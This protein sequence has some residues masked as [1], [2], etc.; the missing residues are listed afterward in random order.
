MTIQYINMQNKVEFITLILSATFWKAWK[1]ND[2]DNTITSFSSLSVNQQHE[3]RRKE[4]EGRKSLLVSFLYLL[5]NMMCSKICF[6]FCVPS[7]YLKQCTCF[8]FITAYK[9]SIHSFPRRYNFWR[10]CWNFLLWCMVIVHLR[11]CSK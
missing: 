10:L 9:L 7:P 6:Q 8:M 2:P 11:A 5:K 1:I 4:N 3:K